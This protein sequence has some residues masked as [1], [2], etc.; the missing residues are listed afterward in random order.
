MAQESTSCLVESVNAGQ[1]SKWLVIAQNGK[2][3]V[4]CT[5]NTHNST[6]LLTQPNAG[7]SSA[8]LARR[9]LVCICTCSALKGLGNV[10]ALSAD[11]P[12]EINIE[13]NGHFRAQTHINC[14]VGFLSIRLFWLSNSNE[15]H[16]WKGIKP[17][18]WM[19]MRRYTKYSITLSMPGFTLRQ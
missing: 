15:R 3:V 17:P 2:Q 12:N 10:P 13:N 5:V 11:F 6:R 19:H 7:K 1:E 14:I 9:V 18:R 8:P 16:L 4:E